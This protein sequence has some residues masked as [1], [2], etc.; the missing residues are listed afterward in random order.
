M[1]HI[2]LILILALILTACGSQNSAPLVEDVIIEL[3][4][5]PNP[6]NVGEST[7]IVSV[8]SADGSSINNAMVAIHGNMDHEGMTPVDSETSENI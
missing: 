3:T 1:K 8:R 2:I 5:E 7:L 6:P 4:V